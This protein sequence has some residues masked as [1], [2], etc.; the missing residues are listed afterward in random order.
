MEKEIIVKP[1]FDVKSFFKAT[2]S[3]LFGP[4]KFFPIIIVLSLI[5]TIVLYFSSDIFSD[6]DIFSI[7][8]PILFLIL[9]S[10]FFVFYIY[11]ISKKQITEN[12][13]LKENI[14]YILNEEY[15]QEKGETFEVKHFWNNIYKVIEKKEFFLIYTH[16]NKA[17]YIKKSDLKDNQYNDIKGLFNS[18]SIKKKLFS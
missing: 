4:L 2:L 16:K 10:F 7:L 8:K 12:P 18:L 15:F 6:E 5:L 3:V 11:K 9:F 1:T 17:N 13:R 14:I